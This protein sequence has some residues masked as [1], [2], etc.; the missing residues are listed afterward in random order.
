MIKLDGSSKKSEMEIA[1]V[2]VP[3]IKKKGGA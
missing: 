1:W 2:Q 3:D